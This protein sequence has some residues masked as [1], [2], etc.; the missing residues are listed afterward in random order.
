[1]ARW[2]EAELNLLRKRYA[3]TDTNE[4]AAMLGKP[5]RAV[6]CMAARCG[7][8]KSPEHMEKI[9]AKWGKT[10]GYQKGQTPWNKGMKGYSPRGIERTQFKKGNRPH[11]W[12]PIGSIFKHT[13]DGIWHIKVREK[14][15]G[16]TQNNIVPLHTHLW[17]Q[18]HGPVPHGYLVRFKDGNP[19]N[20]DLDNLELLSRA[21]NMA[22]NS[23]QRFPP[24]LRELIAVK[25]RL[26]R[27]INQQ[28]P[29]E[30]P[31]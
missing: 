31:A 18:A 5:R 3:D 1:M 12:R 22:R 2:T 16:Q 10:T 23:I 25:A 26:T 30:E 20:L 4:L 8:R 9:R 11:T 27:V 21:E 29:T 15:P 17:E 19:D 28:Q 6:N 14:T 24:E 13:E 7:I